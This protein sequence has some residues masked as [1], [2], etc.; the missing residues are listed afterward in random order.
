MNSYEL[1][2]RVTDGREGGWVG[3]LSGERA[4]GRTN[5]QTDR[6]LILHI[7]AN[8]KHASIRLKCLQ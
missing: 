8:M 6:I 5:R 2:M 3:G 1:I 7:T 4:V